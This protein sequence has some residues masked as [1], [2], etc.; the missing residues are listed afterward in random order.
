[1]PRIRK[2]INHITNFIVDIPT[3]PYFE[4]NKQKTKI[5]LFPGEPMSER[6]LYHFK[7]KM[8]SWKNYGRFSKYGEKNKIDK[9]PTLVGFNLLKY[10]DRMR[11]PSLSSSS[12]AYNR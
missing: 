4:K 7:A 11:A 8:M 10:G 6:F 9:I 3:K 2:I 1:M 5:L 12:E